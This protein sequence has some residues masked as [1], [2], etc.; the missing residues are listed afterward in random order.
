MSTRITPEPSKSACTRSSGTGT[1]P[2]ASAGVDAAYRPVFT[3]TTGL[4]RATRRA[5]RANFR[6]LPKLSR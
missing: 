2:A 6:G 5:S 1:E 4:V 3:A